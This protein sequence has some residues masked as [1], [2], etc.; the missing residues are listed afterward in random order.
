MLWLERCRRRRDR[1]L[2]M[3][4]LLPPLGGWR[5]N[6]FS[7]SCYYVLWLLLESRVAMQDPPSSCPPPPYRMDSSFGK[8]CRRRLC[9]CFCCGSPLSLLL[10]L[11]VVSGARLP[12]QHPSTRM[13]TVRWLWMVLLAWTRIRT[14]TTAGSVLRQVRR[15]HGPCGGSASSSVG[16]GRG[17]CGAS[18][19][20]WRQL[21]VYLTYI[22]RPNIPISRLD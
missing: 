1:W 18:F 17:W 14:R 6:R 21:P 10:W 4:L 5:L 22:N 15:R 7:S 9:H 13:M 20:A 11:V 12:H 19:S 3:F 2:G 16:G 8:L